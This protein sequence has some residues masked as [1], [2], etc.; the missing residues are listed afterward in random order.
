M[1]AFIKKTLRKSTTLKAKK[2]GINFDDFVI[3]TQ[4]I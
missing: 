1:L 4:N 3:I 2:E